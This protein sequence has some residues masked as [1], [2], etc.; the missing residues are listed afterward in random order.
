MLFRSYFALAGILQYFRFLHYGLSVVLVF[1]GI[2][3]LI[4]EFYKV[5]ILAS[6]GVIAVVILISIIASILLPSKK[7]E[8]K[9]C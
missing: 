7:E 3:M 4:S 5:P 9:V 6:L 2:K 1:V 8:I